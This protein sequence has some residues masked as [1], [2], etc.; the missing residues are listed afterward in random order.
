MRSLFALP[1][2]FLLTSIL[3]LGLHW[4]GWL[5]SFDRAAMDLQ[6][7]WHS[8]ASATDQRI[9]ILS[10]DQR[11]LDHFDAEG[12]AFPWPRSL[13]N[14]VIDFASR[15]GA[16]AILFDILFNN[17]SPYGPEVDE[18]FA[19]A[20]AR[21]GRVYLAAAI[22]RNPGAD[23]QLE[24]GAHPPGMALEGKVPTRHQWSGF[25]LP[26]SAIYAAAAG[27]GFVNQSPDADGI[28]RQ[29]SPLAGVDG[30]LLPT[31]G[32]APLFKEQATMAWPGS[33][34]TLAGRQL[35][36]NEGGQLQLSFRE[37]EPFVRISM[38]DVIQSEMLEKEGK[39][40]HI[41]P[42][43][44]RNAYVFVA[45]TAPGL[46]DLKPTPVQAL[47][48][49]VMLHA[50]LLANALDGRFMQQL[51][52]WWQVPTNAALALLIIWITLRVQRLR[53]SSVLVLA[54]VGLA[55]VL[56]QWGFAAGY[57]WNLPLAM[58]W[59]ALGLLLAASYRYQ[60]EG[61]QRRFLH[62]A[63]SR[64]V[65]PRVVEQV[66][67][68]P[69]ALDLGGERREITLLFS[70]L[71]GFTSLSEAMDPHDLVAVLN[72]YTSLMAEIITKY[73]GTVDKFIGDAVMAFW[74]AP[75]DQPRQSELALKAALECLERFEVLANSHKAQAELGVRMGIDRGLCIVGNMGS[76][77]RFDYTAIGDTVNQA[78]RLEGLNKAYG[79]RILIGEQAWL[80]VE[81]GFVGRQ[82]DL[83]RVKGKQQ[84]V[85]V[86]EVL[87]LAD[88]VSEA[89]RLLCEGY[90]QVFEAYQAQQW[91]R[92][93]DLAEAALALQP[94]PPLQRLLARILDYQQQPPSQPWDGVFSHMS[95]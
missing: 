1:G 9:L 22:S 21:S 31:L 3:A 93:I 70:D 35:P 11:S 82:I 38:L 85:R 20:I 8:S 13:Y 73:D 58:I 6:Y 80:P 43:L 69:H 74:G 37:Q 57:I 29:L 49:G 7:R 75:L 66:I 78:A 14:P 92:A 33:R 32:L 34:L 47:S 30:R 39:A 67:R 53:V 18:D 83:V 40:A 24:P 42:E 12:I 10:V 36:L 88:Q 17:T 84:P 56:S 23:I 2:L 41:D 4:L 54:L 51:G 26:L 64:Y 68:S 55:L 25:S 89:Q 91:Q 48:P 62:Q 44:F 52:W 86:Y 77:D 46:F 50:R 81:Q 63:F 28:Y 5:E 60:V 87:G 94:D 71:V 45:Y 16:K 27:V 15:H 76:R 59:L 79:T 61:R 95:K 72:E 19:K 90:A 65:S